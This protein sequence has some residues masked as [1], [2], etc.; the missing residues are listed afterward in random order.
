MCYK[1]LPYLIL[2]SFLL[3]SCPNLNQVKEI[4]RATQIPSPNLGWYFDDGGGTTV[5]G[6]PYTGYLNN[7]VSW[8][9]DHRGL[10]GA[11]TLDGDNDF[12]STP[13]NAINT[14]SSFTISAWAKLTSTD[15]GYMTVV[16]M[17][18]GIVSPFYLHRMPNDHWAFSI[19][20][21]DSMNTP[22]VRVLSQERAAEQQWYHLVG[23]YDA[24]GSKIKLYVNGA[25]QGETHANIHWVAQGGTIAGRGKWNYRGVDY[26]KGQINHV[27]IYNR[28][29]NNSEIQTLGIPETVGLFSFDTSNGYNLA[30]ANWGRYYNGAS[31]ANGHV[32]KALVLD[33]VDDYMEV[34]TH[35]HLNTQESFTV[36]AWVKAD[37]LG[38]NRTMI[39][40]DGGQV[41]GFYLQQANDN[42]WAFT[43]FGQDSINNTNWTRAASDEPLIAGHWY[44]ITGVHDAQA[45][46]IRLYVNGELEDEV[47]FSSTWGAWGNIQFGRAKYNG[48]FVDYFDG[49]IDQ[50]EIY[51]TAKTSSEV[52]AIYAKNPLNP[53]EQVYLMAWFRSHRASGNTPY[54]TFAHNENMYYAYSTDALN[55]TTIADSSGNP[56]IVFDAYDR[57]G[58]RLRDPYMQ[59]VNGKFHLVH[60]W[61]WSNRQA[62]HWESTDGIH[63]TGAN[64]GTTVEDGKFQAVPVNN[65]AYFAWAPEFYYDGTQY[66][67]FWTSEHWDENG[68][69]VVDA[70]EED[71]RF[72]YRTTTDWINFSEPQLL[73]YPGFWAI[74]LTVL[75]DNGTIYGYY[76]DVFQAK[77]SS[78]TTIT[79]T[80]DVVPEYGGGKTPIEGPQIVRTIDGSKYYLYY[81]EYGV[82]QWHA[83]VSTDGMQTF[84]PVTGANLPQGSSHGSVAIVNRRHVGGILRHFNQPVPP[85]W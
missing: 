33:G 3:M 53:P 78:L 71:G 57:D 5:T 20:P 36:S 27:R 56:K 40:K 69:G 45:Q 29:L 51:R 24:I 81:D 9:N 25:L 65:T 72:F 60:T 67:V 84:T 75:E 8:G 31:Y 52:Q 6:H 83:S 32:N 37:S 49:S 22:A 39:S 54:S 43:F 68:N 30:Y 34:R 77:G 38:A 63:W 82:G 13:A 61:G 14:S 1:R 79:G 16:S 19:H 44:H 23:V 50:V 2:G 11:I 35:G 46:K 12:V 62:F 58:V 48:R 28:V 7:G 26:F 42:H 41:S 73:Y 4:S 21:Y 59:Y 64:G 70:N 76:G 18:G 85:G 55:W 15:D 80:K 10:P 17:D 66:Y 47:N 74:D